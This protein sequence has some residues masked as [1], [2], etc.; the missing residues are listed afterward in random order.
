MTLELLQLLC[1]TFS[2]TTQRLL[3]DHLPN[4]IYY[5]D[6]NEETASVPTT[7]VSPERDFAERKILRRESNARKEL[8]IIKEKDRLTKKIQES[9]GLWTKEEELENGLALLSTQ[10]K[11]KEALKLQINFRNKVLG[12]THIN[13][14]LFKFSCNRRQLSIDQL[15]QNLLHLIG[16][17]EESPS[18]SKR[19]SHI[20]QHP[21][22]L[23][24]KKI[25]H[26]FQ[27]GDELVWYNGTVLSLNPETMEFEVEYEGEDD[28]CLFTLLDDISSGDLELL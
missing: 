1:N 20:R 11:K 18:Q 9:G 22:L 7:N 14:D 24:G 13:K 27:V 23:V 25:K 3:I 17:G 16:V 6:T 28:I 10:K 8:N 19:L 4:G 2:V 15:K 12:Q 26:C 21:E 5:N